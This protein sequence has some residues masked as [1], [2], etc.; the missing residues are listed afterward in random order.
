MCHERLLIRRICNR[1]PD[2]VLA[3]QVFD[4]V[5]ASYY[6]KS[7]ARALIM[8]QNE[9]TNQQTTKKEAPP[10]RET[11][12]WRFD[13]ILVDFRFRL[14]RSGDCEEIPLFEH[15]V[16]RQLIRILRLI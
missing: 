16:H 7:S 13:W 6:V 11:T 5:L 3:A 4:G 14:L 12:S 10:L 15:F 8:P 2:N 1:R 9:I